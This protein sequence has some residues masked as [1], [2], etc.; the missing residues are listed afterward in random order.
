MSVN[1][2]NSNNL[3]VAYGRFPVP[4][5]PA[6]PLPQL[7]QPPP[8]HSC[9]GYVSMNRGVS[10][11]PGFLPFMPQANPFAPN[12]PSQVLWPSQCE[13][14]VA[15]FGPDGTLY[16]GGDTTIGEQVA[17]AVLCPVL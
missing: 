17:A 14:G 16:A 6:P 8:P 9:G 12:D 1:P 13:D 10:W 5:Q 7:I 4:N 2:K 11:Q 15:A 3:Y